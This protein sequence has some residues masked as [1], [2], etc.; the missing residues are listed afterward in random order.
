MTPKAPADIDKWMMEVPAANA[1]GS[2]LAVR[3]IESSHVPQFN[4]TLLIPTPRAQQLPSRKVLYTVAFV[5]GCSIFALLYFIQ[6]PPD[7]LWRILS[8]L[9]RHNK[10]VFGVEVFIM[11][12]EFLQS[13]T[14]K[15]ILILIKGVLVGLL[16]FNIYATALLWNSQYLL[17]SWSATSEFL[18]T[19]KMQKVWAEAPIETATN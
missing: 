17:E 12:R 1:S 16:L 19:C 11:I 10:R 13:R 7:A 18:E 6:R 8:W 2:V 15:R 14:G 3:T 4:E 5:Y 9:D